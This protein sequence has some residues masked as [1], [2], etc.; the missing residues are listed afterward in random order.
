MALETDGRLGAYSKECLEVLPLQAG[1][2]IGDLWAL[3]RL[4][5]RWVALLQRAVIFAV[6]DIALLALGANVSSVAIAAQ[7]RR[8]RRSRD[9]E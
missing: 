4:V 2:C 6:A 8:D 7:R 5:P 9:S 1:T 3:P